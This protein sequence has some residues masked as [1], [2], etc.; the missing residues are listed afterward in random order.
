MRNETIYITNCFEEDVEALA[1]LNVPEYLTVLVPCM[2]KDTIAASHNVGERSQSALAP[3]SG[4]ATQSE[5]RRKDL[6]GGQLVGCP[7]QGVIAVID[8]VACFRRIMHRTEVLPLRGTHF[9]AGIL[10]TWRVLLVERDDHV[11]FP[12]HQKTAELVKP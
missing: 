10:G 7:V 2:C 11:V 3:S 8:G 1:V 12:Y 5:A 9:R 4:L 6:W